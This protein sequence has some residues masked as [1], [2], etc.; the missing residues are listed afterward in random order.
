LLVTSLGGLIGV[1]TVAEY[2]LAMTEA[3]LMRREAA[4]RERQAGYERKQEWK[5]LPGNRYT[6]EELAEMSASLGAIKITSAEDHVMRLK[7]AL[8][9]VQDWNRIEAWLRQIEESFP[10][11]LGNLVLIGAGACS[12]YREALRAWNDPLFRLPSS[13]PEGELAWLSKNLSFMGLDLSEASALFQARFDE[14]N[15]TFHFLGLELGFPQ[16][17]LK[18]T[19][20][21]VLLNR[22]MVEL[23][24]LTFSV[25]EA[26]LLYSEIRELLSSRPQPEDLLHQQLLTLFLKCEFCRELEDHA[27][28]KSARWVSRARSVKTTTID[29]FES[30]PSF[31]QRLQ[32]GIERLNPSEHKAIQHWAKHHLPS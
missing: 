7:S 31:V 3:E 4:E 13:A 23:P 24:G 19:T 21:D 1:G 2:V 8:P 10:G 17:G 9:N 27:T 5:K 16:K 15:H 20:Q 29:F 32:A 6:V 22:R 26:S 18:L 11:L 14:S 28:L 25:V 12:F 30:D